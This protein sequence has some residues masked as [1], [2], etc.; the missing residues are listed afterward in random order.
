M[1][2]NSEQ[3]QQLL[4]THAAFL[5]AISQLQ[6]ERATLT[7]ALQSSQPSTLCQAQSLFS[8]VQVRLLPLYQQ[9]TAMLVRS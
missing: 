5:T 1:A 4:R 9:S 3:V 7:S 6:E 8:I 2:L